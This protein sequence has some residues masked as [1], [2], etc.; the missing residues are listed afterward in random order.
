MKR[1]L[2]TISL[3]AILICASCTKEAQLGVVEGVPDS[4][5]KPRKE[6]AY[7]PGLMIV[8]LDDASVRSVE[9]NASAGIMTKS[10]LADLDIALER[11]GTVSLERVF[12]DAGEWEERHREAGLHRFYFVKYDENQS[13]ETKSGENVLSSVKGV[14]SA[15]RVHT[16]KKCAVSN[17]N[18]PYFSSQWHYYNSGNGAK[19]KAGADIN[20]VP[21][22][23]HFTAGSSEVIVNVVDEGVE[24]THEDLNGVVLPNGTSYNF[25]SGSANIVPGDHGTHVAGTIAAINNNGIGVCGIAGGEDGKGGVK[26][27]SSQI[28]YPDVNGSRGA[29]NAIV[30]GAD[31]GAVISQNSWGYSYDTESQAKAGNIDSSTKAAVDY[32]IKYAGLDKNGNQTGPMKGGVVIFAAGND[33]WSMGWPAAY[34]PIVAVGAMSSMGTRAYY[35]NY[36]DWVD[37]A[38]PGGDLQ[39]GPAIMSTVRTSSGKYSGSYQGTSMACPHVSGVAALLVS[40]YGG[41]GFTNEMLLERLLGGVNED[42]LPSSYKIGHLVDAYGSFMYGSAKAPE[43]V[44]SYEV[45]SLGGAVSFAWNVGADEDGKVAYAYQLLASRNRSDFDGLD[46]KKLPASIRRTIV[47]VPDDA[48]AGDEISGVLSDLDFDADYYVALVGY[49]YGRAFSE[50]S[51]VKSVHTQEN[52][53]PVIEEITPLPWTVSATKKFSAEVKVSDPDGHV[54][55]VVFRADSRLKTVTNVKNADGNYVVSV[56]ASKE[57]A[58]QYNLSFTAT[59]AYSKSTIKA[60]TLTIL[61]NNPPQSLREFDNVVLEAVGATVTFSA[62]EYFVDPDGDMLTYTVDHTNPQ[63]VH[64]STLGN[65]FTLTALGYGVDNITVHAKDAKNAEVAL[66]FAVSVR[67]PMAGA[68]VYPSQVTDVLN[69]CGGAPAETH[70]EIYSATG[71]R[72][73]EDTLVTSTFE[74]AQIDLSSVAPGVYTV[75]VTIDGVTTTRTIVKL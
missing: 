55:N 63:V 7:E 28:F 47:Y 43:K 34:E 13:V 71:M 24:I 45:N 25:Y 4:G 18:D 54:V 8:Q 37:I 38:A 42:F 30:W 36:G 15:E 16:I 50:V 20:V 9:R 6:S 48:K 58:G 74:P 35:S 10:G 68:D 27:L 57:D 64:L 65:Q 53:P 67:D 69:I 31:H 75:K 33:G 11:I 72:V 66:S 62:E 56:D 59:D 14:M 17:F 49:D 23:N 44:A 70:I 29:Y 21:V 12:P 41:E 1:F 5:S 60:Y 46:P 61:E 22:W 3:F 2:G 40:Y 19:Y 26:I 39:I 51:E 32:F 73:F 52:N